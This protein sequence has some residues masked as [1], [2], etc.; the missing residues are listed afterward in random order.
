M[1]HGCSVPGPSRLLVLRSGSDLPGRL[2]VGR[3][4]RL[5]WRTACGS[6]G[7]FTWRLHRGGRTQH[8]LAWAPH[9]RSSWLLSWWGCSTGGRRQS[10]RPRCGTDPTEVGAGF[11][12]LNSCTGPTNRPRGC[13]AWRTH[14]QN[15]SAAM[16]SVREIVIATGSSSGTSFPPRQ[17]PRR[18]CQ[19]VRVRIYP[20]RVDRGR[21]LLRVAPQE[22]GQRRLLGRPRSDRP[23]DPGSKHA[24]TDLRVAPARLP[25]SP[26]ARRPPSGATA[27]T[28]SDAYCLVPVPPWWVQGTMGW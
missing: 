14:L 8:G 27:G 20:S 25:V 19:V 23:L 6:C 3:R 7:P 18:V 22:Q 26:A 16:V 1:A 13:G 5:P 10:T 17:Q 15:Q 11:A 9:W 24:A 12:P 2:E 21:R 4:N 28:C